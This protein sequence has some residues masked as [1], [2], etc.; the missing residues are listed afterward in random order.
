MNEN[1][2]QTLSNLPD[3][4]PVIIADGKAYPI[5][6][7]THTCTATAADIR[8]GMTAATQNGVVVGTLEASGGGSGSFAKVTEFNVNTNSISAV[9]VTFSNG[10]WSK[11]NAVTI[12]SYE[13]EPVKDGIYLV[14]GDKIISN[15]VAYDFDKWMPTDGLLS[16]LPMTGVNTKAIDFVGGMILTPR[17]AGVRSETDAWYGNG[18][19]GGLYGGLPY[20]IPQTFTLCAKFRMDDYPDYGD[21]LPIFQ[22][23]GG[24]ALYVGNDDRV[25]TYMRYS[26]G[27]VFDFNRG[28]EYTLFFSCNGSNIK[29]YCTDANGEVWH[30]NQRG[31]Y[32][33]ADTNALS[34]YILGYVGAATYVGKVWDVLFYNRILTENEIATIANHQ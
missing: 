4:Q 10:A 17:G 27:E 16:Y 21:I 25:R 7:S 30:Q 6:Y 5:G 3:N 1:N 12:T 8:K 14:D 34:V 28:E 26:Q 22:V 2:I 32:D 11:G 23:D 19:D 20:P 9:S 31:M 24:F 13:V 33:E 18:E 29:I 15:A